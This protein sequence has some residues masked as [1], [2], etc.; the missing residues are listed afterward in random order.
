MTFANAALYLASTVCVALILKTCMKHALRRGLPLPPGPTGLPIIG[1]VFDIDIAAPWL[2]YEEWGKRY[3][4]P[5]VL[6]V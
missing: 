4:E 3:G 5:S 6:D 2:S 1:N